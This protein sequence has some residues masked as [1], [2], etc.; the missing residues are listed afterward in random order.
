MGNAE[1]TQTFH[2]C[3]SSSGT[4]EKEDCPGPQGLIS[5][6]SPKIT[7]RRRNSVSER[8]VIKIPRAKV[9]L[10]VLFATNQASDFL[11]HFPGAPVHQDGMP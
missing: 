2:M 6:I 3:H 1:R 10:F 5:V 7:P 9:A 4:L 8:R 11:A